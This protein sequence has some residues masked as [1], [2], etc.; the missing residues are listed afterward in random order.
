M[1]RTIVLLLALGFAAPVLGG[2]ERAVLLLGDS[3]ARQTFDDAALVEVL[4]GHGHASVTVLG[5]AT[6]ENGTTAAEWATAP[7]LDLV[8]AELAAH[9]EVEI[10]V[11]FLGG[12]DFLEGMS[13]GG[14]YVGIPPEDEDALFDAIEADLATLIDAILATDSGLEIVLSSYD[15]PNFVETLVTPGAFVCDPLWDDLGQ[16]TPAE[17]N[18]ATGLIDARQAALAAT[19][20]RLHAV[21][22]WGLMQYLFGY[23]SL[24][25][26]PGELPPPGNPA[27]P[28]P[29]EAMRTFGWDCFHLRKAGY[30]GLSERLWDHALVWLLD[31]SFSDGFESGDLVR[32]SS[33]AGG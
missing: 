28:S 8:A 2:G 14:W 5:D 30:L 3:W 26:E 21:R 31:G 23:P 25:V 19:R 7:R 10:V 12:N 18:A 9:P 29:P 24:E 15:Y 17:I 1:R 6:T 20:P 13:G 22:H 33:S 11:I 4:A 32:W 27:L 16:P